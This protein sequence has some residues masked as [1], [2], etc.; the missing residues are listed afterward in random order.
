MSATVANCHVFQDQEDWLVFA[1]ASQLLLR[2]NRSKAAEFECYAGRTENPI[3]KVAF[4][5]REFGWSDVDTILIACGNRCRLQCRYCLSSDGGPD[6]VPDGEFCKLALREILG[7]SDKT[8]ML[9]V[10]FLGVGEPTIPWS[11]FTDCV[12]SVQEAVKEFGR[13]LD[14][15][16]CTDGQMGEPERA[17]LC[18]RMQHIDVSLDGPPSVQNLQRPR[19]DGRESYAHPAKLIAE[20]LAAGK[21]AR[22]RATITGETVRQMPQFV[23]FFADAFGQRIKVVF[24]AMMELEAAPGGCSSPEPDLFGKCFGA[25]LERG[26]ARGVQVRHSV[27]S[28]ESLLLDAA[29]E[30]NRVICLLPNRTVARHC[31]PFWL[32][33]ARNF[34]SSVFA[35]FEPLSGRL[36]LDGRRHRESLHGVLP[37][38]CRTCACVAACA[39]HPSSWGWNEAR[40]GD[41]ECEVRRGV[42]LEILKRAV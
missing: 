28:M 36:A 30:A 14:M 8:G 13:R 10:G 35:R 4:S 39:G 22:I 2:T 7:A 23:D 20:A 32:D 19:K 3:A 31:E 24:S 27:V 33:D 17:W 25:A 21:E 29:R 16:I 15:S 37:P 34:S 9:T 18:G 11:R 5:E 12:S 1:P 38:R 41:G 6:I 40:P 42:M 26:K